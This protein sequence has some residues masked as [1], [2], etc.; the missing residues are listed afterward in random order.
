MNHYRTILNSYPC[1]HSLFGHA[2]IRK[3]KPVFVK[4]RD[5]R[6][7][8]KEGKV[9]RLQH[10]LIFIF[11]INSNFGTF[12]IFELFVRNVG[13]TGRQMNLRLLHYYFI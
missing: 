1:P 7:T 4:T 8:L 13:K 9:D 12:S 2:I 11:L 5:T 6:I 3:C 10:S